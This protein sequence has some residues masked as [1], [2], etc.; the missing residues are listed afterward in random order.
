MRTFPDQ[1]RVEYHDAAVP[2]VQ[3]QFSQVV[4]EARQRYWPYPL[5]LVNDQLVL[6]GDVNVYR[7]S[8]FIREEL[9]DLA[10][11]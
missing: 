4:D 1:V 11:V 2:A 8:K 6:A 10:T 5:V 3:A 9:D 7:L